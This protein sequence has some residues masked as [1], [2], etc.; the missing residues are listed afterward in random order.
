MLW[1]LKRVDLFEN[2]SKTGYATVS[3]L[4]FRKPMSKQQRSLRDEMAKRL[5][6]RARHGKAIEIEYVIF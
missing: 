5:G 6:P 4:R 2:S 1:Y 3:D